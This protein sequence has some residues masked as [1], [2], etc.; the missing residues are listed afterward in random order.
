MRGVTFRPLAAWRSE[1]TTMHA[2]LT[3]LVLTA[4]V[5]DPPKP[6]IT[7]LA[8]TPDGKGCLHASQGGIV[9]RRFERAAEQSIPTKLDHVLALAF[10]TDGKRLAIAGGSPA[11][12][13]IIEL[14]SWP[15]LKPL[16][17]LEGHEDVIYD[18]VWLA[19]GKMLATVSGDRT[20]RIWD[21][22]GKCK[23]TLSG[24]SGPVLSVAVSPDGRW[25][26]SGSGDQTIRVWDTTKWELARALTNH[27]SAVYRLSFRTGGEGHATLASA[28]EDGTVRIWQPGIGR[29]VRIVNHGSP[30][31]GLAW[32]GDGTLMTGTKD[33]V[34]RHVAG[35]SDQVL[36][37]AKADDGRIT[38]LACRAADGQM[39]VG[40]VSGVAKVRTKLAD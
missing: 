11:E 4:G 40:Y 17:K 28:S 26:C 39:V 6:A 24:H 34:L 20:V 8:L 36:A 29:M 14:L 23:H 25:L 37:Q 7:A 1:E 21:A 10:R 2:F 38:T 9:H 30:V 13:G 3:I 5:A 18:C 19:D 32:R 31:L 27:R 33:G 35:D 22:E 15:E 16:A 12:A